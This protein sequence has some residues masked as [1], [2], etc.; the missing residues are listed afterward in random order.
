MAL[1]MQQLVNTEII[2]LSN[3]VETNGK[4]F[5]RKLCVAKL[6]ILSKTFATCTMLL[7]KIRNIIKTRALYFINYHNNKKKHLI[8]FA[9]RA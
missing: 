1:K 6:K 9:L 5:S 8:A 3:F 2:I 7:L 4:D